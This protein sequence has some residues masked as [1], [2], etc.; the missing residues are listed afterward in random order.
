M[1]DRESKAESSEPCPECQHS[2]TSI[3]EAENWSDSFEQ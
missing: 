2:P 1:S 3:V